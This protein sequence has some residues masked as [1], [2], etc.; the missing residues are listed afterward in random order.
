MLNIRRSSST[1]YIVQEDTGHIYFIITNFCMRYYFQIRLTDESKDRVYDITE[2]TWL[3]M[4]SYTDFW[5]EQPITQPD[6]PTP[7]L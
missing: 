5:R 7:G 3:Q 6:G 4:D 1:I 2:T